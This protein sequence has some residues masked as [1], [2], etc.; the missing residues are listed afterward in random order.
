VKEKKTKTEIRNFNYVIVVFQN[1]VAIQQRVEKDIWHSL[2]QFPLIES[3]DNL[4]KNAVFETVKKH[5]K[6]K[7]APVLKN[8][9]TDTQRLT[10]QLILFNFMHLEVEQRPHLNGYIWVKNEELSNFPFPRTLTQY[11]QTCSILT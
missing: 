10:H 7:G 8:F 1:E 2:Y 11:L 3:K 9:K 4:D 5:L 6:I